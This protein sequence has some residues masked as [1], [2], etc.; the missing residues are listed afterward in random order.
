MSITVA[1]PRTETLVIPGP[2]GALEA[3]LDT[4]EGSA[5]THVG[6][7]CHPHPLY[8]GAMTNKVAHTLARCFNEAGAPAVRFNFRGVGASAGVYGEGYGETDDTLA[9]IDWAAARWPSARLWLA[10]F[11]F[12]A[13]VALRAASQRDL[14]RLVSVAP[15]IRRVDVGDVRRPACPWLV[16]QGAADEL[17]D[18]DDVQRWCAGFAPAPDVRMLQGV[19]HFFH[20]RLNELR[21]AVLEWLQHSD[22]A[23]AL[24][25]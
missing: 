21:Q 6:I 9:A 17:V 15:A 5:A 3:V 20:G 8:G 25:V 7:V 24:S 23:G 13:A 14:A 2:A 16:V 10:G 18:P 12:G 1:R 11:S 19:D 22:R 4:P